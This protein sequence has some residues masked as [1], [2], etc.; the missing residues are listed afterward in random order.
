MDVVVPVVGIAHSYCKMW[1]YSFHR[2]LMETKV[3]EID[4]SFIFVQAVSTQSPCILRIIE[5]K[6]FTHKIPAVP[7][8]P[9]VGCELN[10]K[11]TIEGNVWIKVY[12][13]DVGIF[14]IAQQKG[15][16]E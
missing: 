16:V 5:C 4:Q 8:K 12:R 3:F 14:N 6:I 15:C 10:P 2:I 11:L 7:A 9:Y 13:G 1:K